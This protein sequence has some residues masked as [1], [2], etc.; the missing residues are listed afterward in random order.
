MMKKILLLIVVSFIAVFS[1]SKKSDPKEIP[2]KF[3]SFDTAPLDNTF[4]L[5]QVANSDTI[6]AK[7][8]GIR[9]TMKYV[10]EVSI[11]KINPWETFSLF[12]SCYAVGPVRTVTV[13]TPINAIDSVSIFSDH[14]FDTAH[15]AGTNLSE[16]FSIFKSSS[17]EKAQKY[18]SGE[19]RITIQDE[20]LSP[21][22][23]VIDL[24]LMHIPENS[25]EHQFTIRLF[26]NQGEIIDQTTSSIHL[27]L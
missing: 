15:P 4:E 27:N 19:R 10:D 18:L 1:C 20:Y 22:T 9:L 26:T 2:I 13:Y 14:D 8:F 17:Y 12:P 5:P 7:A 16:Y 21:K 11:C 24:L 6:S 3:C 23:E 25:G